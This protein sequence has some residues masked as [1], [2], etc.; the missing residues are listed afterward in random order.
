M[1]KFEVGAPRT[2][3]MLV[4]SLLTTSQESLRSRFRDSLPGGR[5]G[6]RGGEQD[7]GEN[8]VGCDERDEN[9]EGGKVG[10]YKNPRAAYCLRRR[11]RAMVRRG[12]E[13]TGGRTRSRWG[14]TNWDKQDRFYSSLGIIPG[15]RRSYIV[16]TLSGLPNY[17]SPSPLPCPPSLCPFP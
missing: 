13:R 7:M 4:Q 16:L 5:G 2:A 10:G 17:S 9:G 11:R 15:S 14:R 3:R 12:G 1:R 8:G 6:G